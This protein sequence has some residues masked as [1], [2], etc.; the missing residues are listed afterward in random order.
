MDK[1]LSNGIDLTISA[2]IVKPPTP[3]V[4]IIFS[5]SLPISFKLSKKVFDCSI[6][7][8]ATA[9]SSSDKLPYSTANCNRIF[10]AA[11]FFLVISKSFSDIKP[12]P[13]YSA[14]TLVAKEAKPLSAF[15]E[16]FKEAFVF[17]ISPKLAVNI[18]CKP[19]KL[20]SIS[21]SSSLRPLKNVFASPMLDEEN[22]LKLLVLPSAFCI[23]LI[24]EF[25]FL[26]SSDAAI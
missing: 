14:V 7:F 2:S 8:C 6:E 3:L 1:P 12:A 15:L 21:P 20:D 18:P 4:F 17:C 10:S 9:A 13:W 19:F 23:S 5:C 25:N 22:T 11:I 16:L 26:I 24:S